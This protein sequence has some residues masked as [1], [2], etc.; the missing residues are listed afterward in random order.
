MCLVFL[1]KRREAINISLTQKFQKD[2]KDLVSQI[3][4]ITKAVSEDKIHK[5]KQE[6][7]KFKLAIL[8]HFMEEDIKLYWYL[9]N[10]Y[11][12]YE[13]TMDTIEEF[14]KSMKVVQRDLL[15]FLDYY[16]REDIKIDY[17]FDR[18]F[19]SIV[20]FLSK[21]IETEENTLYTLYIK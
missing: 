16:S 18:K 1:K 15:H 21:R 13:T 6:L 3:T 2:H 10:Y 19:D 4:S 7:K 17:T 11:K 20:D 14:E 5:A 12:D 8:G 9:K